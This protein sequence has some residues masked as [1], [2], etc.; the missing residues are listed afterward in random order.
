MNIPNHSWMPSSTIWT[1][2]AKTI[3]PVSRIKAPRTL[4][5]I[6]ILLIEN[7]KNINSILT[8]NASIVAIAA[9]RIP[10]FI[11]KVIM[12]VIVAGPAIIG[13]AKG[14]IEISENF[15]WHLC[16]KRLLR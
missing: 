14:T 8:A 9:I 10:W 15:S 12:T 5:F 3:N 13:Q 2:I 6:S 1:P 16:L 4:Y 7:D 11:P